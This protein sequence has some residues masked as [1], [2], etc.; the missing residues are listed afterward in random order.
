MA[1]EYL[2]FNRQQAYLL[3]PSIDAMVVWIH[4]LTH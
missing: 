1:K 4:L 2:S 3:P